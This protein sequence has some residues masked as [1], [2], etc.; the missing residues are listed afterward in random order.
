MQ[1]ENIISHVNNVMG[2]SSDL[3]I[4]KI[5]NKT[6]KNI[7]ICIIYLNTLIDEANFN[8]FI[9]QNVNATSE[10]LIS[11]LQCKLL[12]V[13]E[14]LSEI[15]EISQKIFNGNCLIYLQSKIYSVSY[16]K[17]A[18]R[19]IEKPD[20]E[21]SLYGPLDSFTENINSNISMIRRR[22]PEQE[23]VFKEFIL[24]VQP[25]IKLNVTYIN[26][27]VD[28]HIL[29]NITKKL[30]SI[31]ENQFLDSM[32]L[33][34][35]LTESKVS[36]FPL[37]QNVERPDKVV[38]SLYKG[39][40]AI[41]LNN[42]PQVII[43]PSTLFC[44]YETP[45]DAYLPSIIGS[46]LTSIR[47]IGLF[48]SLY[49]PSLYIALTSVNQ[50]VIRLEIMMAIAINR[51]GVPY[52]SYVEV[53]IM[54]LLMELINEATIRLPRAIGGSA[55]IVGGL[56]IGTSAAQAHIIS[57]IMIIITSATA[58][59]SF[60]A[61]NYILGIAWRLC[62]YMLIFLST[63]WGLY[64]ITFGTSLLLIYLCN[65]RSFGQPYISL[66]N[67]KYSL[68]NLSTRSKLFGGKEPL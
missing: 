23:L 58:I 20:R 28:T 65:L 38:S 37:F 16:T 46:F 49:L 57:N 27:I 35:V 22:I 7:E 40:I 61:A 48:L 56:I 26:K 4:K 53:I 63:L 14:E 41:L 34:K 10:E 54:M 67:F 60:T 3:V 33:G 59:G 47:F 64:G 11:E 55:T 43:L 13:G 50:D 18:D 24:D 6:T 17:L 39:K 30:N 36:P 42:S 52:P 8:L 9:S 68:K 1:I 44:L 12:L 25:P 62:A 2:E 51:E 15:S 32:Q 66:N 21:N 19:A 29:N 45:D 31:K 5:Y